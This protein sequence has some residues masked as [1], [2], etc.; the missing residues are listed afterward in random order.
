[1]KQKNRNRVINIA[2]RL[3][4]AVSFL[5]VYKKV[6]MSVFNSRKKNAIKQANERNAI[7]KRKIFVM[8]IEKKFIV[9]TREELR[10]YNKVGRKVVKRLSGTH[11]LDF[12]Y[13]NAIVYET[14]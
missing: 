1:M 5:W 3:I 10:R 6:T 9:G 14:V 13:K 11:L 7:E 12:K 2:A 4:Y 8:Q